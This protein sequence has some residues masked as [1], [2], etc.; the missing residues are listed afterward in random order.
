V[1]KI[2]VLLVIL[3]GVLTI[4]DVEVRIYAEHQFAHRIDA[5]VAGAKS[6]V[7]I[8]SFPFVG[9]LAA[10][11]TVRRIRARVAGVTYGRFTFESVEVDVSGVRLDRTALLEHQ[12]IQV[13]GIDKGTVKAEMTE[14]AVD[15]AFGGVPVKLD[16]GGIELTLNGA[17]VASR[18]SIV[19]NQ[20]RLGL[21]GLPA[22]PVPKL[23]VLPCVT[24]A[25]VTTGH[26]QLTCTLNGIPPALVGAAGLVSAGQIPAVP[27]G[28]VSAGLV[29]AGRLSGAGGACRDTTVGGIQ[30]G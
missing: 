6:S 26:L 15:A 10:S 4:G 28:Q 30:T 22:V 1:A 3:V 2:V 21:A 29:S 24:D 7:S 16:N 13:L 12:R 8:S 25:V 20:L 27:A 5:N 23:S 18:L 14:A 9:R 11:G 17:H 19:D